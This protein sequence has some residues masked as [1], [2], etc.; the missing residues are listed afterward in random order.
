MIAPVP[1]FVHRIT[2]S[3]PQMISRRLV[4]HPS[5]RRGFTLV[6]IMIAVIIIGLLA[7]MALPA[8]NRVRQSARNNRFISDLRTFVTAFENYLLENG[9]W[10][11]NAGAGVVPVGMNGEVGRVWTAR[12]SV[13]GRWNWDRNINVAAGV[14]TVSVT[15]TDADMRDID[16]KIDDGNLA[17]GLFQ[18]FDTRYTYIL[19][20]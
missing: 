7:A 19:E 6:E 3:L 1:G 14:S 11:P 12:N 4:P 10:P 17:T 2:T 5:S 13:G 8:F 9:E 15:A 20:N 16:A 18:K